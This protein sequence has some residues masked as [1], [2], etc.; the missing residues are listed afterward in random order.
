MNQ[1][2][3]DVLRKEE[4]ELAAKLRAVRSVL[5]VYAPASPQVNPA[6]IHPDVKPSNAMKPALPKSPS[7][8]SDGTLNRSE[9]GTRVRQ[10]ARRAMIAA[11][12]SAVPTRDIVTAV[13]AEGVAIRGINPLNAISALL[14]RSAN[15]VNVDRIGWKLADN[16]SADDTVDNENG[17]AEA[18]PDAEE[19]P[20]SSNEN[21]DDFQSLLG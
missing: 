10:I 18:A 16:A 20:T 14:S 1:E 12:G 15:F 9:Y 6:A 3:I 7:P 19:A 4:A 21:R 13:Q 8:T 17:A 2:V 11:N 5:D